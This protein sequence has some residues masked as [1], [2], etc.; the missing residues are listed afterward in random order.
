MVGRNDHAIVDTLTAL[1]QVLQAQQNPHVEGAESCGLDR[2]AFLEKYCSADVHSKKEVE[3]LEL[4]Q[5]NMTVAD[6]AV[7]FEELSRFCPHYNEAEA[8][9]SKCIKFENGLCR[10]IKPFIGYQ[11]TQCSTLICFKCGKAGHRAN[12]CKSVMVTCFNYGEAGHISTQ[13]QKPKKTQYVKYGGKVFTLSGVEAP[14]YDNLVRGTC[15]INNIPL[16]TII[17]IGETHAII[18]IDYIKRLNLMVY[19]M[20][21]NM[22]IDTPTNGSIEFNCMYIN[23]YNK[24]IL[25][26]EFVKEKGSQFI[27]AR[28]VE[29]FMKYEAQV[30]V[31]F[32]SLQV[33]GKATLDEL[34]IACEFPYMF[35]GDITDLPPERE[36]E[37]AID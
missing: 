5:G 37:F 36:V 33:K 30:F 11:K 4:K 8:E 1:A 12:E 14:K 17:D 3:F 25:F 7:K 13:C 27:S 31:M 18:S 23:Y 16:I 34:P 29:E 35:P 2:G 28:Q 19:A 9:M 22:V 32:V 6:Y 20:N 10:E 15:F 26:P 21:D 24:T